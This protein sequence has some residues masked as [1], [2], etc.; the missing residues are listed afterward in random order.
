MI[1]P[2]NSYPE[3]A[4]TGTLVQGDS[5]IADRIRLS[6][7]LDPELRT[8]AIRCHYFHGVAVLCGTVSSFR[9]RQ[10]AQDVIRKI[11]GIST[12]LNELVIGSLP[13]A[14][15]PPSAH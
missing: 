8:C 2:V 1:M 6:F 9:L 15:V 12:I 10:K 7:G 4:I 3:E 11:P 14:M 5:S 13:I